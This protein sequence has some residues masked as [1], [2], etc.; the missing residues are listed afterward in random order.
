MAKTQE[1]NKNGTDTVSLFALKRIRKDKVLW[2]KAEEGLLMEKQILSEASH[3]FILKLKHF[4]VSDLRYYFF[5]EFMPG[6]DLKYQ[7]DKKRT[8]FTLSEVRFIAAQVLMALDYLHNKGYV[9]RDIKP[10]NILMDAEGYVKLADFGIVDRLNEETKTSRSG[11]VMF[12]APEAIEN[13]YEDKSN[14][15]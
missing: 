3:P 6:R 14:S 2:N 11:S 8:P 12:M 9:H 5:L 4:F 10:E 13:A 7:L 1:K 15:L